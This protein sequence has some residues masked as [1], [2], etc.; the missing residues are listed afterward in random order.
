MWRLMSGGVLLVLLAACQK[1]ETLRVGLATSDSPV[2]ME[3]TATVVPTPTVLPTVV[4]DSPDDQADATAVM[5]QFSEAVTQQNEVVAL[6]MLSP[7]AQ[8]VAASS[9]LHA[10]LGLPAGPVSLEVGMIRLD[11]G[12]AT[13]ECVLRAGDAQQIIRLRLVRLDGN[14]KIDGRDDN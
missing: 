14:W 4:L 8:Q 3:Q 7:S 6:L 5:R 10:F 12:V 13:A 9:D 2:T 11:R 1:Q